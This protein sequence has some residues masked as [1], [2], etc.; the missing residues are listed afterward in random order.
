[1]TFCLQPVQ[2]LRLTNLVAEMISKPVAAGSAEKMSCIS[3]QVMVLV[4]TPSRQR[5]LITTRC[6]I[7][8]KAVLEMNLPVMMMLTMSTQTTTQP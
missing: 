7:F 4:P 2:P 1:M 3:G 6:F 8:L 5:A